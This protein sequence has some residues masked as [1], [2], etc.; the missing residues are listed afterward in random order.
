MD[1]VIEVRDLWAAI[2]RGDLAPLQAALEP[3]ARWRAVDDGPWN[4]DNRT[5]ILEVMGRNLEAGLAGSIEEAFE[6]AGRVVVAFRPEPSTKA[7]WPLE[8]GLRHLVVTLAGDRITELKGCSTR[9][10]ALD[11][12]AGS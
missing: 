2:S 4:C 1:H 11:Y 5:A 7:T 12:A 8:N 9:A 3:N 10:A 6:V